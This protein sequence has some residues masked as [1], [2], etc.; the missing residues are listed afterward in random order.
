MEVLSILEDL[1]F[2]GNFAEIKFQISVLSVRSKHCS[3]SGSFVWSKVL[4]LSRT[5]F[6]DTETKI[7]EKGFDFAPKQ[8]KLNDSE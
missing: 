3:L 2:P 4:K 5:D 8:K 6:T 7:L 1:Q